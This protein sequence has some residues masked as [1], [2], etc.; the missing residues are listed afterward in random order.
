MKK[1]IKNYLQSDQYAT[2]LKAMGKL[3]N[4]S[5]KNIQL[6]LSQN[7]NISMVAGFNTWKKDFQRTVNKGE[8]S[9]K[10]WMPFTVKQKDENGKYTRREFNYSAFSRSFTLPSQ[11]VDAENIAANYA[12]GILKIMIP[13]K[14]KEENAVKT[15]E[16]K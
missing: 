1:G 6:L 3:H 16:I 2:F 4:Y 12:D 8:K 11:V 15:I 7:K 14:I 10:I 9:L 5:P 13:K